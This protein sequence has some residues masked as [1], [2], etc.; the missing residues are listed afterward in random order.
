MLAFPEQDPPA[1]ETNGEPQDTEI[2]AEPPIHKLEGALTELELAAVGEE[3][4]ELFV[5]RA[6]LYFDTLDVSSFS[7]QFR[8]SLSYKTWNS[9]R[10]VDAILAPKSSISSSPTEDI[11]LLDNGAATRFCPTHTWNRTIANTK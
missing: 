8:R 5:G 10:L 2:Q 9:R 4:A 7:N 11:T 3:R 1:A 6:T